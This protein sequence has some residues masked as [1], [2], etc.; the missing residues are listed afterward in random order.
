MDIKLILFDYA[1]KQDRHIEPRKLSF[2][3]IWALEEM[4]KTLISEYY[5]PHIADKV[6]SFLSERRK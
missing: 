4:I 3:G 6:M 1:D 5:S 2:K